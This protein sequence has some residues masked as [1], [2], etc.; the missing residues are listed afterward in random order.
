MFLLHV[1][2]FC[3]KADSSLFV[4]HSSMETILLLLYVDDILVTSNDTALLSILISKLSLE[5][6][7]K[8]LGS[9]H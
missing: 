5:F 7:M 4:L 9:L 6:A 1:G 8:D 2:F 3:S